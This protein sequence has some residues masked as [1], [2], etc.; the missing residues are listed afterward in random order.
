MSPFPWKPISLGISSTILCPDPPGSCC[1]VTWEDGAEVVVHRPVMEDP[2]FLFL[3]FPRRS[4]S[5]SGGRALCDVK[6]VKWP[7]QVTP[8]GRGRNGNETQ[9]SGAPS[10]ALLDSFSLQR[11]SF[12][13]LTSSPG[14]LVQML[15]STW[16]CSDTRRH[17]TR[18]LWLRECCPG[19]LLSNKPQHFPRHL[20]RQYS[21]SPS[22]QPIYYAVNKSSFNQYIFCH[23]ISLLS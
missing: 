21:A 19:W 14:G 3:P 4:Q 1:A 8:L 2:T 22:E 17:G 9:I 15:S 11:S 23:V 12:P 10:N 18:M 16:V 7:G 20:A 5:P 6:T 13:S